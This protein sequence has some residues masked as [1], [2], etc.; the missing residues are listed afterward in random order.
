MGTSARPTLDSDVSRTR[1]PTSRATR[2]VCGR[3]D[4]PRAYNDLT[5]EGAEDWAKFSGEFGGE[6]R[7]AG[8]SGAIGQLQTSQ[9][10]QSYDNNV[11][12]FTWSD[13]AAPNATETGGVTTG[14]YVSGNGASMSFS[15]TATNNNVS[16]PCTR[17]CTT[18]RPI[19]ASL[20][21]EEIFVDSNLVSDNDQM[22]VSAYRVIFSTKIRLTR[23]P[24]A[25]GDVQFDQQRQH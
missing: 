6:V 10:V 18:G 22:S 15:V 23:W 21:S 5:Q 8:G 25:Q 2:A 16:W 20:A 24:R 4:P 14:I 11:V 3:L 17:E 13:G 19:S 1:R 9:A 12:A 7:K